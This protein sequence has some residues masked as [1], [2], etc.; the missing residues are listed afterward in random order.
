MWMRWSQQTSN[1]FSQHYQ[2]DPH[3]SNHNPCCPTHLPC[4]S[5]QLHGNNIH[6]MQDLLLAH[7]HHSFISLLQYDHPHH[8]PFHQGGLLLPIQ[9]HPLRMLTIW[10]GPWLMSLTCKW[11]YPPRPFPCN[12]GQGSC[13]EIHHSILS[14][15]LRMGLVPSP[16]HTTTLC[17]A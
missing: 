2:L 11:P 13:T 10:L 9:L 16:R 4:R 15:W 3:P 1:R 17:H 14:S 8:T 12:G 6:S 5:F 7:S